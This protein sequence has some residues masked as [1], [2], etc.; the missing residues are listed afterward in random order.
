M[1]LL[2]PVDIYAAEK[3]QETTNYCLLNDENCKTLD[4]IS[5]G[6]AFGLGIKT[7][8]VNHLK[9]IHLPVL[10]TWSY[11]KERFFIDSLDVGYTLYETN[12]WMLNLLTAPGY[13]GIY[14]LELNKPD[15]I[16][17]DD[18]YKLNK[19]KISWFGGVELNGVLFDGEYQL[20]VLTDISNVHDGHE[21]RF[22]Y[23]TGIFGDNWST[24]LGFTWN[25]QKTT[26]YYYGVKQEE[27]ISNDFVAYTASSNLSPF[28]R[29]SWI[30][31][32]EPENTWRFGLQYQY[33]GSGITNS[34]IVE[35]DGVITLFFGKEFNF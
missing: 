10:P 23:A 6:V 25:D 14:F 26:D 18:N 30:Q 29:L 16:S 15:Y 8:P 22:A 19:R 12:S 35:E 27:I 17:P 1:G 3:A 32:P 33:L 2:L 9:D 5:F 11:Y 4:K 13:E 34:P 28:I 20:E 31:N 24:T 7:N 21:V